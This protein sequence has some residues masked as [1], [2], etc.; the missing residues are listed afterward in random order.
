MNS[1]V[2]NA[3]L[4]KLKEAF[5]EINQWEY[6]NLHLDTLEEVIPS[7]RYKKRIERLIKRQ[8]QPYWRYVNTVGK[9]VAILVVAIALTFALPMGVSAVREPVVEFFVNVYEK[10][11][12]FFYDEDDVARAPDTIE[13]VYTLGY[14]PEG[15][16]VESC[17]VGKYYAKMIWIDE[18]NDSITLYQTLLDANSLA[19]FE[20]SNLEIFY[21]NDLKIARVEKNK[22]QFFFW[23]SK[24]YSFAL[25]F[26]EQMND[27]ENRA[28]IQSI[29][30]NEQ[31]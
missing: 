6:E 14:V 31:E 1:N 17:E 4:E 21:L 18:N 12:E 30:P 28:C 26:S 23:N 19:D 13:I 11:V 27:N 5:R 25:I 20:K 3:G 10:F 7:A 8:K 22:F 9:R 24:E 15:Y 29:M 16:E 2:E